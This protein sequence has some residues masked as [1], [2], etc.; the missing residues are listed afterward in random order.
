MI[1]GGEFVAAVI[2]NR[3]AL[4]SGWRPLVEHSYRL[5]MRWLASG[6]RR[7]ATRAGLQRLIVPLDPWRYFELPRALQESFPGEWLD[8]SS[9]KLL[10]SYLQSRSEG[11]WVGIDLFSREIAAWRAIDPSLDLRVEDARALTFADDSF[12]G[13]LCISVIEH[14]AGNDDAQVMREMWRV[15]RPGG[16]VILTTNV[17]RTNDVVFIDERRYQEA[18]VE[19]PSGE[20]FFERH[21]SRDDIRSRLMQMPWTVEVEE[22]ARMRRPGVHTWYARLAPASYV[23]GGALRWVMPSG[24]ARLSSPDDLAPGEMGVAYLVLRK[25]E[26]VAASRDRSASG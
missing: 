25:P 26:N 5:G 6:R 14:L 2:S 22:Y 3:H 11:S 4:T 1:S 10:M 21:Y 9:P 23:V 7:V 17:A 12:D 15:L 24:F 8:V 13:C 20:V 18:S 16:A 19:M